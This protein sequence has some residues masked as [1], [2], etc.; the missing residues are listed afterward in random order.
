MLYY[1]SDVLVVGLMFV[2]RIDVKLIPVYHLKEEQTSIVLLPS[3]RLQ[4]LSMEKTE[5]SLC[6]FQMIGSTSE[7]I[8]VNV[9]TLC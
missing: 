6:R 9:E 5:Y 1:V 7:A 3:R 4:S 2:L 8:S